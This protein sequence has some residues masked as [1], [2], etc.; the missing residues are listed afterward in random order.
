MKRK[1]L[2]IPLIAMAG[3]A[4]ADDLALTSGETYTGTFIGFKNHRFIFK[5]SDG[6]ERSDFAS[7]V[8]SIHV[9]APRMITAQTMNGQL[10]D[11]L[12]KR[13]EK[14]ILVLLKD[15]REFNQ[16][17][18]L[19]KQIDTVPAPPARAAAASPDPV[20]VFMGDVAPAASP[21]P[22]PGPAPGPA[23]RPLSGN[24]RWRMTQ[25]SNAKIISQGE[26]VDVDTAIQKG[27]VNIVHFHLTQ[28]LASTRE[29]NYVEALTRKSGGR[30]VLLRIVIADW[31]APIC[32]DLGLESLP[33]FW[34]YSPSGAQSGKLTQ[35]FTESDIDEALSK[36][37]RNN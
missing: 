12:F 13:Y 26:T 27:V 1:L 16:P 30:I 11:V 37:R 3:S 34:F 32:K 9:D 5:T 35:R 21:A 19:L 8:K 36:A 14:F 20:D 7:A 29:G 6:T 15:G 22:E 28:S 25:A 24:P 18:T 4:V 10:N 33:Q 31:K 23:P 2:L 17:A